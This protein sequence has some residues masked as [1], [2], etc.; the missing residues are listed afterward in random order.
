[1]F[2]KFIKIVEIQMKDVKYHK[3]KLNVKKFLYFI[4]QKFKNVYFNVTRIKSTFK[5]ILLKIFMKL[6]VLKKI[7][8]KILDTL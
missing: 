7:N 4:A 6:N 2:Y 3:I 1:M 8:A 5:E